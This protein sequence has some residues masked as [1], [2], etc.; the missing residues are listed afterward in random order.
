MV[1]Q[2]VQIVRFPFIR[3]RTP[4]KKKFFYYLC[5]KKHNFFLFQGFPRFTSIKETLIQ[6]Q[7]DNLPDTIF[8]ASDSLW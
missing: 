3:K 8:D 2:N 7:G 5:E 4:K 1:I 6:V